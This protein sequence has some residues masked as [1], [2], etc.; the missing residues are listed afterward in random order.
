MFATFEH[1][2]SVVRA[3]AKP[4][5][6]PGDP[7]EVALT[8]RWLDRE[9]VEFLGLDDKIGKGVWMLIQDAA[10]REGIQTIKAVRHTCG[11]ER[12]RFIKS[13]RWPQY[14]ANICVL[15]R[16]E[17]LPYWKRVFIAIDQAAN[18]ILLQGEPDETVSARSHRLRFHPWWGRLQR[19]LDRV[20]FWQAEHCRQCYE[21]EKARRDLPAEYQTGWAG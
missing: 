12:V 4:E 19:T 21:W 14:D 16:A 3:S 7:Y 20:F 10:A 9:N 17:S 11:K 5:A 13:K 6:A 15:A 8:V 1:L 2:T 18:V